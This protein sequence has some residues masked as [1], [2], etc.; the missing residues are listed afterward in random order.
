MTE[1]QKEITQQPINRGFFDKTH[2]EEL[3]GSFFKNF[4]FSLNKRFDSENDDK[5]EKLRNDLYEEINKNLK[6]LEKKQNEGV[7]S[8]G[9]FRFREI[10][11]ID[12]KYQNRDKEK[13]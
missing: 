13:R 7:N 11:Y 6:I 2:P 5:I 10:N 1:I 3:R 8:K 12:S 4:S 9:K